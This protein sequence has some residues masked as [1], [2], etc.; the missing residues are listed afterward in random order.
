FTMQG[1]FDWAFCTPVPGEAC[2]AWGLYVAGRFGG[3]EPATLLAPWESNELRDDVKFTELVADIFGALR[4]AQVFREL[5]GPFRRLVAPGVVSRPAGGGAGR[6]LEARETDVT[7]LFGDLR[8]F[9]KTVE[10][11]GSALL[12]VLNRVST[13]LG[14]MTRNILQYRGAIADFLGDAALGF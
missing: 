14:V 13:A 5:P 10:E 6:G 11:A 12:P 1:G 4:Q 8:G 7:V 2:T 9:S 3:A